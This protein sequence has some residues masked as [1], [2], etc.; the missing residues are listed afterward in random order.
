MDQ[1]QWLL[2]N[3][4][5]YDKLLQEEGSYDSPAILRAIVGKN[6]PPSSFY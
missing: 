6:Q 4:P 5:E 1:V 2:F 3:L